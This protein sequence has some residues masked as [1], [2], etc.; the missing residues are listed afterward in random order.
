VPVTLMTGVAM[1]VVLATLSQLLLEF[2]SAI[3]LDVV[4]LV[5][6]TA[7]PWPA[8]AADVPASTV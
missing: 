8:V 4:A 2:D 1:V 7:N 5:L 6:M 3:G